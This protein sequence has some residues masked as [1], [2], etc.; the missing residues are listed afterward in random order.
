VSRAFAAG[1]AGVVGPALN[2]LW[3]SQHLDN[4]RQLGVQLTQATAELSKDR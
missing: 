4:L 2:L 1:D 3:A